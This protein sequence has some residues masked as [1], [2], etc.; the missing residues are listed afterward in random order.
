MKTWSAL[1]FLTALFLLRPSQA[2]AHVTGVWVWQPDANGIRYILPRL[3]GESPSALAERYLSALK[4]SPIYKDMEL[5]QAVSLSTNKE[6]FSSL[7][8]ATFDHPNVAVIL[9]RP[10]QMTRAN[11]YLPKVVQVF[12]EK[13]PR[14]F[15][16][17]V[18]L[19][20]ALSPV[21]LAQFRA[22]INQFEGQLGVGGDDPHPEL[23]G[24]KGRAEATG[25]ISIERDQAIMAYIKE[26]MSHG[27]GRVFYICGSMQRAALVTGHTL[28]PEI[29]PS[30][31]KTPQRIKTM[32]KM[33]LV[34][35]EVAATPHSE[36]AQAAGSTHFK[37]ANSH[38]AAV[39]PIT[40]TQT[41]STITA[42]NIEPD[43]SLGKV[44]K[45]IEFPGNV[46]FGTQFH[47]E[48]G[49]TTE[50]RRII[51]YVAMG[52]KLG[53]RYSPEVILHCI[54]AQLHARF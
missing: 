35:V 31:T 52:W 14:L 23:Y 45:A 48:L 33:H 26:Y 25:D 20:T 7:P 37:T 32:G 49:K 15:S 9:N 2:A 16:I 1:L 10:A 12:E 8:V 22:L 54:E 47:P 46:G 29:V 11:P 19:E 36:I 34:I 21:D 39:N 40:P 42:Y 28:I 53:G 18:G 5:T 17:P 27:K 6:T 4:K 3:E 38:H 30:L 51:N 44:V 50:E 43:Q 41:K 13:G 24:L